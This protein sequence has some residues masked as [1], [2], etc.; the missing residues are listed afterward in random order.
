MWLVGVFVMRNMDNNE[1]K[2]KRNRKVALL[3]QRFLTR[4]NCMAVSD[5]VCVI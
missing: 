5:T 4:C 2:K 3:K 1:T